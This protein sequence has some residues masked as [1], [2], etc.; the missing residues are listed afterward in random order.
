MKCPLAIGPHI[1]SLSQS[2]LSH[3]SYNVAFDVTPPAG[4]LRGPTSDIMWCH[5]TQPIKRGQ[6][7]LIS[8]STD[9]KASSWKS[10]TERP[11][12]R[13]LSN[14]QDQDHNAILIDDHAAAL[15]Q[16][17]KLPP[18]EDLARRKGISKS[19]RRGKHHSRRRPSHLSS[20]GSSG[21]SSAIPLAEP[22]LVSTHIRTFPS[23]TSSLF[24]EHF[25]SRHMR[26]AHLVKSSSPSRLS[27]S[28]PAHSL[29][30]GGT[31]PSPTQTHLGFPST[32]SIPSPNP[33]SPIL[34][35]KE[36]SSDEMGD[37][38]RHKKRKPQNPRI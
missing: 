37:A 6:E 38:V 5:I 22:K 34:A 8:Y 32:E 16:L 3:F 9:G 1:N 26:F 13:S 27:H 19:R 28:A 7:L 21:T 23:A 30:H 11:P 36:Y 18:L 12:G 29:T 25:K 2:K 14:A 17:P 35:D 20:E 33:P 24:T 15:Q 31:P 4:V 10:I